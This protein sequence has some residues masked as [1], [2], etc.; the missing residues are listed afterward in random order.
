[1]GIIRIPAAPR[2]DTI[3]Y[4]AALAGVSADRRSLLRGGAALGLAAAAFGGFIHRAGA[5]DNETP[6][7]PG[8]SVGSDPH[9]MSTG[10]ASPVP[11]GEP[12]FTLY[13]PRLTSVE[14]GDKTV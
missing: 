5:E 9:S 1:M 6:T 8:E 11:N 13:D 10:H 7:A 2:F 12:V 4:D 3:G 14:P